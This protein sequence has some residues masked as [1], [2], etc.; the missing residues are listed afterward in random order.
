MKLKKSRIKILKENKRFYF[1]KLDISNEKKIDK[2]FKK[3]KFHK[4]INLAAQAGVRYSISNPDSYFKSNVQGFYNI[5]KLCVKY[6]TKHLIYASTSSVYGDVNKIL[7]KKMTILVNP[8]N[9]MQQQKS[10]MKLWLTHL[11]QFINCL[12]LD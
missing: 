3:F 5:L 7:L 6:K 2:V 11:V 8:Y 1:Y 10:L 9:S 12:P 4:V